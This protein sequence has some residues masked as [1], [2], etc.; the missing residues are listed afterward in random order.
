MEAVELSL[1][2]ISEQAVAQRFPDF[3]PTGKIP[4]LKDKGDHWEFSY[5]LPEGMIGGSPV[6]IMEKTTGKVLKIYRTQ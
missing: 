1:M 5:E 3:D 2:D 4:L 6:G